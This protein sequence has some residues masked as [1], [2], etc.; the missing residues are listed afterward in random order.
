MIAAATGSLKVTRLIRGMKIAARGS[1]A[2]EAA[3]LQSLISAGGCCF[4]TRGALGVL[5]RAL[6]LECRAAAAALRLCWRM[7]CRRVASRGVMATVT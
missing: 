4:T 1:S 5:A 3:L 6:I 2:C 7:I